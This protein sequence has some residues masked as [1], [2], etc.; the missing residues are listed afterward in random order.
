VGLRSLSFD[1]SAVL[2]LLFFV[3]GIL[4]P[5]ASVLWF[6]NEAMTAQLAA[7][8]QEL[9]AAYRGQLRLIGDRIAERWRARAPRRSPLAPDGPPAAASRGRHRGSCRRRHR[10]R[11]RGRARLSRRWSSLADARA[12][13]VERGL[14]LTRAQT[15]RARAGFAA[16]L[17][18]YSAVADRPRTLV[19][20]ARGRGGYAAP[21]GRAI[22]P[23]RPGSS[24][25]HFVE[26]A[27]QGRDWPTA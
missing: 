24:R 20:G 6:M 18:E 16:A 22:R 19:D 3:L 17:R 10:Q 12:D 9:T 21:R 27:R 8:R 2:G 13:P 23:P 26:R 14:A 4:L 11:C 5:T 25:K 1:R 7:A 15:P